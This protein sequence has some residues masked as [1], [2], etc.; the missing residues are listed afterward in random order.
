MYCARGNDSPYLLY[1]SAE[2]SPNSA[3]LPLSE[4]FGSTWV[5]SIPGYQPILSTM[6]L[7][8]CSGLVMNSAYFLAMA[9]LADLDVMT[10]YIG[11]P[12]MPGSMRI[13]RILGSMRPSFFQR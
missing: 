3:A 4:A 12:G 9:G 2:M 1:V 13:M 6:T 11:W 5:A 8:C 7:A 10:T